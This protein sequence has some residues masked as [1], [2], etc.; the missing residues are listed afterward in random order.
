MLL[1]L[2]L[3]VYVN[4][5][6]E[7]FLLVLLFLVSSVV[8]YPMFFGKRVQRYTFSANWQNVFAFFF[9]KGAFLGVCLIRV[10]AKGQQRGENPAGKPQGTL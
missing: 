6:K 9:E 8:D 7:L 2:L 10:K 1:V 3:S 5:V 4:L